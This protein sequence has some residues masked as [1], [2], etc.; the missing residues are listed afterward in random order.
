MRKRLKNIS[1]RK[2]KAILHQLLSGTKN[3]PMTD[4][5][6]EKKVIQ[7]L[8]ENSAIIDFHII[9]KYEEHNEKR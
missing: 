8:S 2:T 6:V 1:A 5:G 4:Y 7:I 3:V 9:I